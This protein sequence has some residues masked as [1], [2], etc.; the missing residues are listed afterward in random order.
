MSGLF[1]LY[2]EGLRGLECFGKLDVSLTDL[3]RFGR[4]KNRLPN[5]TVC[6]DYEQCFLP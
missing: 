1:L 5:R 4:R 6:L 2:D 3:I